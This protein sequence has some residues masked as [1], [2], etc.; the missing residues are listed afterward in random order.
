MKAKNTLYRILQWALV[1]IRYEATEV[2]NNKIFAI[3]HT[4][5]NLPLR[6]LKV[7]TEEEYEALLHEVEEMTKDNAGLTSLINHVKRMPKPGDTEQHQ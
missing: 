2:K 5:H 1:E 6:L 4:F 3:A 7:S